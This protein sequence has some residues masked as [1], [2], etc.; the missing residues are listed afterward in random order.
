MS[1]G[2]RHRTSFRRGWSLG[3][4]LAPLDSAAKVGAEQC[5]RI[6]MAHAIEKVVRAGTP[7]RWKSFPNVMA[8]YPQDIDASHVPSRAHTWVGDIL[9]LSVGGGTL[10]KLLV[11]PGDSVE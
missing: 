10:V 3:T 1:P 5:A 9:A 4:A 6:Q 8:M 7:M 11:Q 2:G